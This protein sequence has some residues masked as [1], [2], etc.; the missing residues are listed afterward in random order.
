MGNAALL[1][2]V[3]TFAGSPPTLPYGN[4]LAMTQKRPL[5]R[6]VP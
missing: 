1:E 2:M 5:V 3:P 4:R 6:F